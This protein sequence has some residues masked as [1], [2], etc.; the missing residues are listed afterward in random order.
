V[1]VL[2]EAAPNA[3]LEVLSDADHPV[4]VQRADAVNALVREF[5]LDCLP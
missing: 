5:L 4:H 1:Q 2:I 3:R